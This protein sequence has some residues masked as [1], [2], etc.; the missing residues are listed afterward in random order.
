MIPDARRIGGD[1]AGGRAL[2][3]DVQQALLGHVLERFAEG[4]AQYAPVLVVR[5][6]EYGGR[7]AVDDGDVPVGNGMGGVAEAVKYGV[8]IDVQLRGIHPPEGRGLV[9][10]QH[11]VGGVSGH[12]VQGGLGEGHLDIARVAGLPDVQE[13][14]VDR[15][16]DGLMEGDVERPGQHG[17]GGLLQAR[18]YRILDGDGYVG[19]SRDLVA[20]QVRDGSGVDVQLGGVHRV[21]GGGLGGVQL[22][23]GKGALDRG[24][25]REGDPAAV[26]VLVPD[27]EEGGVDRKG[28]RLAK[29]H[30]DGVAVGVVDGRFDG[31]LGLVAGSVGD[32][33]QDAPVIGRVGGASRLKDFNPTAHVPRRSTT[34]RVGGVSRLK[35]FSVAAAH[36]QAGDPLHPVGVADVDHM[37]ARG[38]RVGEANVC[39]IFARGYQV[40]A[41]VC[42]QGSRHIAATIRGCVGAPD[43]RGQDRRGGIAHVQHVEGIAA[44]RQPWASPD[45][46]SF[47]LVATT[48]LASRVVEA[49][50]G[51]VV[52][53]GHVQYLQVAKP[54]RADCR[55]GAVSHHERVDVPRQNQVVDTVEPGE[56]AHMCQ[57]VG[58]GDVCYAHSPVVDAEGHHRV[59]LP[60][61]AVDGH[62]GQIPVEVVVPQ[63]AGRG[64]IACIGNI[65]YRQMGGRLDSRQVA[66]AVLDIVIQAIHGRRADVN[67]TYGDR[68]G[69]V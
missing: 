28:H 42:L 59:A 58:V 17:V 67:V 16:V 21:Q 56:L 10:I 24:R 57:V 35:D 44:H 22:E 37:Y 61:Q 63:G 29:V 64:G 20:R 27:V 33:T 23:R 8:R 30:P 40:G 47:H 7:D 38:Y 54:R 39:R 12:P 50:R 53:V 2:L 32:Q 13:A 3:A 1:A 66:A 60:G 52:R 65:V 15:P 68:R 46:Q 45:C 41:A 55:V 6:G 4:D 31:R 11:K 62:V 49:G 9:R 43:P 51:G 69:G 14:G 48:T 5:G 18:R 34:W 25:P 36:G 26:L 19:G